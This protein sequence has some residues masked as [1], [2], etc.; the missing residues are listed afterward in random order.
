MYL[1]RSHAPYQNK[2]PRAFAPFIDMNLCM[3]GR[4]SYNLLQSIY[5][6]FY[7][8]FYLSIFL[9]NF[10]SIFLVI[11]LSSFLSI[12]LSIFLSMLLWDRTQNNGH[13]N[14]SI[15]LSIHLSIHPSIYLYFY[16]KQWIHQHFFGGKFLVET[17]ERGICTH[18]FCASN[19]GNAL[20]LRNLH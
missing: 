20:Y 4:P 16:H 14:L 7:L 3:Q 11:F 18:K 6:S 2:I 15:Q 9:S 5:L 8:P 19:H 1:K 10:L 12:F 13:I 17:K